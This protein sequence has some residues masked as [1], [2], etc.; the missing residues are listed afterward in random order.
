MDSAIQLLNNWDQAPVV[1]KMDNAIQCSQIN[2]YPL[3]TA[4]GFPNT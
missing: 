4:I 3:V 1:Q 2:L